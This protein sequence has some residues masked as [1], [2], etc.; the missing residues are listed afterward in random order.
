MAKSGFPD[1]GGLALLIAVLLVAVDLI[2]A[3]GIA[4]PQ[5][6]GQNAPQDKIQHQAH[7][8][9]VEHLDDH[10]QHQLIPVGRH[11]D[12]QRNRFIT[13]GEEHGHQRAQADDPGRIEIGR[14]G[15]ETALR[16]T[17]QQCRRNR[18]PAPAARQN[19]F[20]ALAVAVLHIFNEQIGQKQE[21]QHLGGVHQRFAQNI[22]KQ[23]HL[24][25]Q[26]QL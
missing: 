12:Q 21:G 10:E 16:H 17:A 13:G 9:G 18:A 19:G 2:G 15:R 20:D 11:G 5:A 25:L 24:I 14:N 4:A 8:N 7:R 6:P 3:A 22:Q 26:K 1:G 23:F